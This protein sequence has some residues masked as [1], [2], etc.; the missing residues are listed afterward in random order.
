MK[1]RIVYRETG[2]MSRAWKRCGRTNTA[3]VSNIGNE[4]I[5]KDKAE[6]A[7]RFPLHVIYVFAAK[8]ADTGKELYLLI[9]LEPVLSTAFLMLF[10]VSST[11]F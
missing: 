8:S 2:E 6:S 3:R 10:D 9:F 1:L 7:S 11:P 4:Q 5:Q